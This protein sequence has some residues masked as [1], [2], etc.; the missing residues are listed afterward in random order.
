MLGLN[1][2][3]P[4]AG[5]ETSALMIIDSPLHQLRPAHLRQD[6]VD[7]TKLGV[8]LHADIGNHLLAPVAALVQVRPQA[9]LGG[10]FQ[11]QIPQVLDLVLKA[12]SLR[13]EDDEHQPRVYKK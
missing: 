9:A 12:P 13:L 6:V 4:R 2:L 5:W 3:H 7:P 10:D 8:D 11:L 1:P